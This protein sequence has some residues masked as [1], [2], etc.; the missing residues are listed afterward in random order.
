ME[1]KTK[2]GSFF[3]KICGPADPQ[4]RKVVRT[5]QN[6][7]FFKTK[8]DRRVTLTFLDSILRP[9]IIRTKLQ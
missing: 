7:H 6:Y 9:I 8:N 3:T 1:A 4:D 2:N 5:P